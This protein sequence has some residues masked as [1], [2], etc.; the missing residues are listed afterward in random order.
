MSAARRPQFV[1]QL[2][3]TRTGPV[4]GFEQLPFA[5]RK[6]VRRGHMGQ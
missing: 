1:A 5:E 2:A 3:V 6:G 4:E